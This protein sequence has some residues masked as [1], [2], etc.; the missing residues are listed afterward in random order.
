MDE[1][2]LHNLRFQIYHQ[3]PSLDISALTKFQNQLIL[4]CLPSGKKFS[5]VYDSV[6]NN[7]VHQQRLT[8]SQ[9]IYDQNNL[10]KSTILQQDLIHQKQ[11]Q[12]ESL[13]IELQQFRQQLQMR[14]KL[15]Q[16]ELIN[17]YADTYF[18]QSTSNRAQLSSLHQQ[19]SHLSTTLNNEKQSKQFLLQNLNL[20]QKEAEIQNL[21]TDFNN[22]LGE[23]TNQIHELKNAFQI[24][25]EE[26]KV[27]LLNKTKL[28]SELQK[29]KDKNKNIR[30]ING[31]NLRE[32]E[33]KHE[34]ITQQMQNEYQIWLKIEESNKNRP[35]DERVDTVKDAEII[36]QKYE[37]K[38]QDIKILVNEAEK[39]Y[40]IRK[41]TFTETENKVNFEL[42]NQDDKTYQKQVNW[43]Y[44]QLSVLKN[45]VKHQEQQIKYLE[46][47]IHGDIS[48]PVRISVTEAYE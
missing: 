19:I 21:R 26:K 46:S 48:I 32:M 25:Q 17:S 41:I 23:K 12:L 14:S 40:K 36:Q 16:K 45:T 11:S 1:S 5:V 7:L 38:L 2:Q 47:M 6:L 39:Q 10:F 35:E 15:S 43:A 28:K 30:T 20:V 31:I 29:Q 3:F 9:L 37:A 34:I 4:S 24:I 8:T 13:S 33:D 22:F 44:D 18:T 27:L 42:N